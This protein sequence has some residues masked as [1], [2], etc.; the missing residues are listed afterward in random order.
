MAGRIRF[1]Q[2]VLLAMLGLVSARAFE[3]Q[4]VNPALI[5]EKSHK[6][7]DHA[8]ELS[9]HRGTI[10][11]RNGQ[12]LAVSLDV[13]SVAANPRIIENRRDAA[14]HLAKAL[15]IDRRALEKKLGGKRYFVWV[16]RQ[17]TPDEVAAVKA[18]DIKGVGF[19]DEAKRF[20]PESE[21]LAN[22]VG[23]V[24]VD[25]KGLEGLEL[26]YDG[27]L[28]G[29]ERKI[30]VHRDG[31]GRIIY[32]RGLQPE[33]VNDGNTLWLTID[34]RI[35]HIAFQGL[36]KAVS[37]NRA[38]SGFVI[39]SN[40][41]TGEIL[42]LTSYPSF[43]PNRGS[44]RHLAGHANMAI[45]HNFE[46]GSV[47]K[48]LWVSWG[49]EKK[50][51]GMSRSIFC[52]N[53]AFTFHRVTIH[54]HEKYGWLP[55][56][57]II[58]YSSNIGMAKLMD[59][60]RSS[61]MHACMEAFGL[62]EP[63]GIDFPGEPSGITRPP[64]SWTSV[65][66][67]TIAF[68]QG[69]AVTGIQLM[70]AFNAMVNGGMIMKPHLVGRI[71]DAKNSTV[72]EFRPTIM[73]RVLSQATSDQVVAV[74]KTVTV[75]GGTG[76]SAALPTFQIFGKTGTAQKV[77]HLTGAYAEGDYISSF[78]GGVID[79]TGKTRMTMLVCINEPR[80]YYYASIV[81]C[82]LFKDIV[83]QC[84]SIMDL[85]PNITIATREGRG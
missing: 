75:K 19:Y 84:A 53:G 26:Q 73:R 8:V 31:M 18:L 56:S 21:S 9:P 10:F 74:M 65:D 48:P 61:D 55:V 64:G 7:F 2:F 22:L 6:R 68:G 82:P 72:E 37:D 14:R 67:A 29:K 60:V 38:Q 85:S 30:G 69:F 57:D 46:P 4:V 50:S 62:L 66:K 63:T 27:I 11:D 76:E 59:P 40:P 71:T 78:I 25:S 20:Y 41:A 23:F 35:Q 17:V 3:F 54:D 1:I 83:L 80:P 77:D 13:K 44:Y 28:K 15:R 33:T 81:A 70:T 52:E 36:K 12:P 45:T 79:A 43:D 32:A 24:G 16:K 49:L 58:K 5:I 34:R 42:A 51:F 47:I 39:I